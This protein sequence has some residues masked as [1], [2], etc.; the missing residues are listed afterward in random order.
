[1]TSRHASFFEHDRVRELADAGDLDLA[2]LA[3]P[4]VLGHA[5]G[6]HPDHVAGMDGDVFGHPL[7]EILDAE[8]HVAGG[9]ILHYLPVE[10]H[11]GAHLAIIGAGDDPR[12]HR[13]EGVGVLAAPHGAVAALPVALAHV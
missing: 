7:D 9:E 5:V 4:H 11:D 1:M 6:A 12:P 13:L 8:D 3:R 2:G 10:F